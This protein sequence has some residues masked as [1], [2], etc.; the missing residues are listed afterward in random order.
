MITYL[1]SVFFF[2]AY[3][4][5]LIELHVRNVSKII[6]HTQKIVGKL[7]NRNEC[8]QWIFTETN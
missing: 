3:N 5:D 1:D 8:V 2:F 6:S 4:K 7:I